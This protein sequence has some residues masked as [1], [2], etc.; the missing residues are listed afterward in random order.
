MAKLKKPIL[1]G[2]CTLSVTVRAIVMQVLNG[3]EK[4]MKNY[5][6]KFLGMVFPGDKFDIAVWK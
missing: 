1:H 4:K 6:V 5:Q 2:L 3:D